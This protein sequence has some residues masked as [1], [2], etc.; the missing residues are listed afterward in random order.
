[1]SEQNKALAR[2]SVEEVWNQGKLEVIDELVAEGA[3]FHDP[4]VP[5]GKFTGPQGYRQFVE[6]YRGAFPDVHLTVNDQ[7]AEGDKVVTRWTAT[8]THKGSL[9][10]IPATNKQSTV[11][12]TDIGRYAEGKLVEE[13]VSYDMLGMLQQLGVV[14]TLTP[15]GASA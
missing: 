3:N 14:P 4:N 9:M 13:W 8:G 12:G 5:G 10:G 7:I 2:R 11:T 15:A 1:M 6:I